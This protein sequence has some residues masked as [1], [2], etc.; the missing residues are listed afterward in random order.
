MR[1]CDGGVYGAGEEVVFA[2]GFEVPGKGW[3]YFVLWGGY[4]GLQPGDGFEVGY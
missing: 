3:D 1:D 4:K 2:G